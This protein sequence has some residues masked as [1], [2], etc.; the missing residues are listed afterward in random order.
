MGALSQPR[1]EARLLR[2]GA[3]GGDGMGHGAVAV[4]IGGQRRPAARQD[5]HQRGKG[6]GA[7]AQPAKFLGHRDAEEAKRLH[8]FDQL[9]GIKPGL[10]QVADPGSHTLFDKARDG[11]QD[12]F[13]VVGKLSSAHF[14]VQPPSA[15]KQAAVT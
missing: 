12:A 2:L 11:L 6:H 8:L 9:V 10:L 4:H 7:Q 5:L 3:M 1:Q 13:F 14:A 15:V